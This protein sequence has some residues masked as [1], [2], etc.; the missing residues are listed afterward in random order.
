MTDFKALGLDAR[1]RSLTSPSNR[2]PPP[3]RGMD[4]DSGYQIQTKTLRV[5]QVVSRTGL[6]SAVGTI[7]TASNVTVTATLE[8]NEQDRQPNFAIP[9]IAVFQATSA[10]GSLQIYPRYGNGILATQ[11]QIHSGFDW[12][13]WNG[14]NSVF[15]H[16]H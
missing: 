3:V 12:M 11:Y 13:Q 9:Y 5:S 16:Q 4:F 1:G 2:F 15:L 14:T 8:P 7:N 6:L 10:V